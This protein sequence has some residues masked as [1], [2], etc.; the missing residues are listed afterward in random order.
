MGA[1]DL[2]EVGAESLHHIES[3]PEHRADTYQ[4]LVDRWRNARGMRPD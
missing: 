2:N 3:L 1:P 4:P